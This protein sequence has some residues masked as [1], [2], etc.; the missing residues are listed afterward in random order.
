[1][2]RDPNSA[3]RKRVVAT[4][5]RDVAARLPERVAV[6]V[7]RAAAELDVE[8]DTLDAGRDR[9]GRRLQRGVGEPHRA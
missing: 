6:Q 7:R 4:G 3:S 2:D 9:S 8:A 5:M 1:M